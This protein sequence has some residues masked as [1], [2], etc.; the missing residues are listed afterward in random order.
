MVYFHTKMP[1]GAYFGRLWSGK[2][3]VFYGHLIFSVPFWYILWTVGTFCS[4]F[5]VF[6]A[7][8]FVVPRKIWQP[9]CVLLWIIKKAAQSK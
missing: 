3:G 4:H 6:S 9:C 7:F 2:Y 5:D 8:W 1:N